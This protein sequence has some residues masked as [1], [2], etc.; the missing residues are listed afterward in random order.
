MIWKDRKGNFYY[1]KS[2]PKDY[3]EKAE[4]LKSKGWQTAYHYNQFYLGDY[5]ERVGGALL[6]IK[7]WKNKNYMTINNKVSRQYIC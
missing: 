4:Y 2:F 7:L 3:W 6:L 1:D 5:N